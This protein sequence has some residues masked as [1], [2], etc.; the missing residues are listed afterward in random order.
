MTKYKVYFT[1]Q[2]GAER[3]RQILSFEKE[4]VTCDEEAA[5]KR[6][7][8]EAVEE[9][10]DA[11]NP[12]LKSVTEMERDIPATKQQERE[13][14]EVIKRIVDTLGPDSYVA[15]AF[16]GCFQMAANNIENDFLLNWN[17]RLAAEKK[18][19]DE[20]STQIIHEQGSKAHFKCLSE[21]QAKQIEE[22]EGQK[23]PESLRNDLIETLKAH[24]RF[25][26]Y[27]M[28]QEVKRM[29]YDLKYGDPESA[30]DAASE[31]EDIQNMKEQNKKMIDKLRRINAKEG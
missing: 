27:W 7:V 8:A 14:L 17:D 11:T 12:Q 30:K 5:F 18:R 10:P 1:M 22:L 20:L 28:K 19:A 24:N 15:A 9:N 16:N 23:L 29:V 6:A 25:C 13:A 26:S 21:Q 31:Y 2:A 3:H 4:I